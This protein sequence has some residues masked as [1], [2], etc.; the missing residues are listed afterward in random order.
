MAA[1]M[2]LLDSSYRLIQELDCSEKRNFAKGLYTAN[3]TS[4]FET[5]S[6]FAPADY[7]ASF[8]NRTL[9]NDGSAFP[10]ALS[11]GP[12]DQEGIRIT[13]TSA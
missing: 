2:N 6:T 5:G 13:V 10:Y 11:F 3:N 8:P 9:A 1:S 4:L 7:V 12:I